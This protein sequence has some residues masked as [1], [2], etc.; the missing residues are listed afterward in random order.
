VSVEV[1]EDTVAAERE[2]M[3]ESR[4]G[5][6]VGS[7]RYR[8]LPLQTPDRVRAK[9]GGELLPLHY[10]ERNGVGIIASTD[11]DR[12]A[13]RIAGCT[14]QPTTYMKRGGRQGHLMRISE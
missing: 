9:C 2:G 5:K 11:R 3:Q 8:P 7:D 6:P 1:T 14:I 13:L 10:R 4:E 12:P